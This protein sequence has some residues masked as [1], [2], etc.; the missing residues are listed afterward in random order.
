MQSYRF[1]AQKNH[2]GIYP[3]AEAMEHSAPRLT[4]YKTSKGAIQIPYKGFGEEKIA[5]ISE[6]AVW[7]GKQVERIMDIRIEAEATRRLSQ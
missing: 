1:A 6:I 5:L 3:G 4:G 2:L 7:C